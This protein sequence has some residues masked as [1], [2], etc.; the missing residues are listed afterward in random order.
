MQGDPDVGEPMAA[1]GGF[2][3]S[4]DFGVQAS[5]RGAPGATWLVMGERALEGERQSAPSLIMTS[6]ELAAKM[7][8][9][10][11]PRASGPPRTQRAR[12]VGTVPAT[13][14]A[15]LARERPAARGCGAPIANGPSGV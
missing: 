5:R 3:R 1:C 12:R 15:A 9:S 8:S 11:T 10:H 14:P 13:L 6:R 7:R 2:G 4:T